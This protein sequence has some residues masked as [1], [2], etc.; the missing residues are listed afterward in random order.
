[1][2]GQRIKKRK[3]PKAKRQGSTATLS[4]AKAIDPPVLPFPID[5]FPPPLR[6]YVEETA[7][8]M[9][10]PPDFIAVPMLSFLGAAIGTT[11]QIEIRPEWNEYPT[12]WTSVVGNSGVAKS[13]GLKRAADPTFEYQ[14]RLDK[15]YKR[16][17]A[18]FKRAKKERP[19]REITPPQMMQ[20]FTTDSTVEALADILLQNPT[21]IV[22]YQDELAGWVRQFNQ[23]KGK[24]GADRQNWSSIWN[25][26]PVMIN[27]RSRKQPLHLERPFVCVTGAIPP[28]VLPDLADERGREDGF[29]QRIL[30]S[31]PEAKA[32]P[33]SD[34]EL[35]PGNIKAY[36]DVVEKLFALREES[37]FD[38]QTHSRKFSRQGLETFKKFY[39][40]LV[41]EMND[42]DF[43]YEL[44]AAWA[45]MKSYCA[46]LALILHIV[47]LATDSA[48][49]QNVTSAS[50][51]KAIRLIEYFKSHTRKVYARL[52]T[53]DLDRRVA[54]LVLWIKTNGGEASVR[55]V[56]TAKVARCKNSD[57]VGTLFKEIKGQGWGTIQG[58]MPERGGRVSTVL[59]LQSA[60]DQM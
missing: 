34:A 6:Q 4:E 29:I 1:V 36:R 19:D 30:F 13:P 57:D 20:V 35:D 51:E 52:R 32:Q 55:D 9:G 14:R 5:V 8:S 58:R 59:V 50:V 28:D 26:S 15:E 47:Q 25:S 12:V 41:E 39:N 40:G 2:K 24:S 46:R 60:N 17:Y 43:P 56:V 3:R 27:R 18:A 42:D 21:G 45:K 33:W 48:R 38:G 16:E 37:L 44:R 23:Y 31:Y 49:Q 54:K 11:R 22:L 53:S 10:V 7:E